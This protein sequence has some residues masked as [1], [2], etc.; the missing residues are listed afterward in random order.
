[1]GETLKSQDLVDL[2]VNDSAHEDLLLYAL[3]VDALFK[4]DQVKGVY[5]ML[6][7]EKLER[8]V[9]HFLKYKVTRNIT[10]GMIKDLVKQIKMSVERNVDGVTFSPYVA[11]EDCLL[12]LETF[13]YCP[14]SKDKIAVH[15][16][17]FS[18]ETVEQK[19]ET[20]VF[21][22]FLNEVIVDRTLKPDKELQV[23]VQEMCGY[24]LLN[25]LK[26]EAVFFLYGQGL[27]GKSTLINIL[28]DLIGKE[29]C[30]ASSIQAMTTNRWGP[31]SLIG[32]KINFCR[33]EESKYLASDKFKT[34]IS[35]EPV[36]IEKKYG[37]T[38]LFTPNAKHLFSLNQL[39]KFDMLDRGLL[40]RIKIIPFFFNIEES[41][42][43]TDLGR[44]L[45]AEL[46]GIFAWALVGAKRLVE[47]GYRFTETKAIKETRSE[48]EEAIS[49]A[50]SFFRER[51]EINEE[52]FSA[53]EDMY[54]EYVIWCT[55][56]GR[57]AMNSNNFFKDLIN[58]LGLQGHFKWS[59][60]ENK[61]IRGKK[62]T[63]KKETQ[64]Y[65][66]KQSNL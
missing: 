22:K 36:E 47:N 23:L 4:Y 8:Y 54:R 7:D 52:G 3:D 21:N 38:F 62:C 40:R 18:R 14:F 49:G 46:P 43:D 35:G 9:Y 13:E 1:M 57:K 60:G 28:Q 53:N 66:G 56:N 44:R 45:K 10:W 50:I 51:Y 59:I 20:P 15:Y 55:S 42:K 16:V 32:K 27:N 34:I 12:N 5:E 24:Y 17:P 2:F 19:P 39:P 37:G 64:T 29:F 33:D 65:E 63:P 25:N 6:G 30:S 26:A 48:F 61:T 58:I 11:L 31:V 41:K